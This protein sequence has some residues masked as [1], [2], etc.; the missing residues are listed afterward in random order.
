MKNMIFHF[1]ILTYSRHQAW[2]T[3]FFSWDI[4][5]YR[6]K[7]YYYYKAYDKNKHGNYIC[8]VH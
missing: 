5:I 8:Y 4:G 7:Y 1:N 6:Y 2:D 3:S